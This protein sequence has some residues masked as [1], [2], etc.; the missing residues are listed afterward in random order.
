MDKNN[1]S[2]FAR[3]DEQSYVIKCL[4]DLVQH[5]MKSACFELRP[6]GIY[7]THI[8]QHK[9]ILIDLE[10][11]GKSFFEYDCKQNQIIGINLIHFHKMVKSIKKKDSI[12]LFIN[13]DKPDFLGIC[14]EQ[15]QNKRK[16]TS[17]V[18]ITRVQ[19]VKHEPPLLSRYGSSVTI[20]TN[21]FQKMCKEM[22][23]IGKLI[24]V[25]ATNSSITFTCNGELY[26]REVNLGRFDEGKKNVKYNADFNTDQLTQL[27]KISGLS[28]QMHIYAKEGLPLLFESNV[29]NIG[30]IKIYSKSKQEI[31]TAKRRDASDD[32]SSD[33]E[34]EEDED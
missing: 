6:E 27:M 15:L 19:Y 26:H 8:D 13:R 3:T 34:D 4:I 5:C 29:G 30:H 11:I 21:E 12:T 20:K 33:D 24:K 23:S 31:D 22:N 10:L 32:E 2:F 9:K 14:V 18:K 17:Y 16:T 25:S 1:C 28:T 7:L